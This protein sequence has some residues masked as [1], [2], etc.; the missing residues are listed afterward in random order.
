[1]IEWETICSTVTRAT[2]RLKVPGGWL[3]RETYFDVGVSLTFFP[4][5][6]HYW[7]EENRFKLKSALPEGA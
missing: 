7:G 5:I 1:M 6:H 3:V 2:C 4:D